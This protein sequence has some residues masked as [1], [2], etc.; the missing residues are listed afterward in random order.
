[1]S[2]KNGAYLND[3]SH[4]YI[5]YPINKYIYST[6][7]GVAFECRKIGTVQKRIRLNRNG[8][9]WSPSVRIGWKRRT[10]SRTGTETR[11]ERKMYDLVRVKTE[12]V[13]LC[14]KL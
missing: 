12:R 4:Y 11:D 10:G 14:V 9:G 6:T 7:S 1:M 3:M 13:Q 2:K 5:Y 8:T